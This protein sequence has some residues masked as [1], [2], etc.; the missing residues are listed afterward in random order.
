MAVGKVEVEIL[1]LFL[2]QFKCNHSTS[3]LLGLLASRV[4]PTGVDEELKAAFK[5]VADAN[6]EMVK[7]LRATVDAAKDSA[8]G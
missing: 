6:S 5:A 8:N 3:V 4:D 2:N 1:D 7:Q